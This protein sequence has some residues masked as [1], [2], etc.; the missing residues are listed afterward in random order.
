MLDLSD[1]VQCTQEHLRVAGCSEK[2]RPFANRQHDTVSFYGK[3]TKDILEESGMNFYSTHGGTIT[4]MSNF[5]FE[6]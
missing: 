1:R 4:V 5:V 3:M 2:E 6:I